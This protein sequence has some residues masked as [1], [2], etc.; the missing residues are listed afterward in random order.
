MVHRSHPLLYLYP[1][2]QFPCPVPTQHTHLKLGHKLLMPMTVH[3]ITGVQHGLTLL[4]HKHVKNIT[5]HLTGEKNLAATYV[6]SSLTLILTAL[7]SFKQK[8]T[9]TYKHSRTRATELTCSI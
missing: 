9:L 4:R 2:G 6:L 5:L 1:E 3:Q 8:R 7:L